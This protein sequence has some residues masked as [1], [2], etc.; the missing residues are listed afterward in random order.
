GK[1]IKK[2]AGYHQFHAVNVAVE[3]T[4]RAANLARMEREL[5]ERQGTYYAGPPRDAEA[6]DRRI[7]VVWHTQGSGKSLT[8]AFYA[9]RVILHPALENP[10]LVI[11]TDRIDLDNQLFGV[12]ARCQELLRQPAIPEVRTERLDA[13]SRFA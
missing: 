10:T 4:L 6:G 3:E 1:L 9:G 12:F 2:V 11:L 8:M 5:R 13:R 7:G